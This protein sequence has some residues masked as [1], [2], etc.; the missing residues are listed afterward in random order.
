LF[1]AIG[2][3]AVGAVAL[4]FGLVVLF[5]PSFNITIS[6]S[7]SGSGFVLVDGNLVTTPCNFSWR[8]GS[9]HN[10]SASSRASAS[11]VQYAYSS[12]SDGGAQSHTITI[13]GSADYN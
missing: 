8:S 5:P 11:G 2:I 4:G 1:V 3:I 13:N 12:W 7:P 6:S 9:K 10:I